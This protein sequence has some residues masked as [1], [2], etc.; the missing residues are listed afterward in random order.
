[1][2]REK[3]FIISFQKNEKNKLEKGEL[4]T[5]GNNTLFGLKTNVGSNK[6][7]YYINLFL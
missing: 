4:L 3:L 5:I 6:Y 2:K 7:N 1:L